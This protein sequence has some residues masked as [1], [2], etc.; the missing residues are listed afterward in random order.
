MPG[1]KPP[2]LLEEL[3]SLALACMRTDN[4]NFRPKVGTVAGAPPEDSTILA[5]VDAVLQ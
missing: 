1:D 2:E 4:P 5:R 3:F